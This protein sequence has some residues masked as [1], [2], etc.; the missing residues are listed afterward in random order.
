[1]LNGW[2][3]PY[4]IE[5]QIDL[6]CGLYLS[7][8]GYFKQAQVMLRSSLE[9]AVVHY[10]YSFQIINYD[11]LVAN[12]NS[13]IP[14]FRAG[15]HNMLFDLLNAGCIDIQLFNSLGNCYGELNRFVHA[16]LNQLTI[17]MPWEEDQTEFKTERWINNACHTSHC[18]ILLI[19]SMLKSDI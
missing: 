17:S 11:F 6:D 1:M 12:G 14:A 10:Y 4:L 3:L 16:N 7:L 13:R 15:P 19:L 8:N 18:I 5:S 9:N 2:G